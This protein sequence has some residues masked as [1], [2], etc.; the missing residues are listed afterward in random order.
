[1]L[2]ERYELVITGEAE[3][4]RGPLGRF[5]DLAEQIQAE[6]LSV[7]PEILAVLEKLQQPQDG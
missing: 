5:L 3:I 2:Q 1:M 4:T 7:P 6:G